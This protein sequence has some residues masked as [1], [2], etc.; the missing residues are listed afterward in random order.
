[1]K[2][3]AKRPWRRALVVFQVILGGDPANLL[4]RVLPEAIVD[5]NK[6]TG[7]GPPSAQDRLGGLPLILGRPRARSFGGAMVSHH[8]PLCAPVVIVHSP[9]WWGFFGGK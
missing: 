9:S 8:V 2:D 3:A 4:G 6:R 5:V 1:L 7:R